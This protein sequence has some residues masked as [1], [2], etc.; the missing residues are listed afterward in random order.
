MRPQLL[1]HLLL[2]LFCMCSF[3]KLENKHSFCRHL[4]RGGSCS[5]G[6]TDRLLFIS[7]AWYPPHHGTCSLVTGRIPLFNRAQLQQDLSQGVWIGKHLMRYLDC[8]H[9]SGRPHGC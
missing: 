4:D 3:R 6:D 2:H 1:L 7:C 8:L 5:T 9:S